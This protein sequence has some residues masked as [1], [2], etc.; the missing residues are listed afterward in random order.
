MSDGNAAVLQN[1]EKYDLE[2][3]TQDVQTETVDSFEN[4]I[5]E[6]IGILFESNKELVKEMKTMKEHQETILEEIRS[7]Q[8]KTNEKR[9][10]VPRAANSDSSTI[11]VEP[12]SQKDEQPSI[13]MKSFV[14]KHT[15]KSVS[16]YLLSQNVFSDEEEHFGIKWRI[17]VSHLENHLA[18]FVEC[19]ESF[20]TNNIK[21]IDIKFETKISKRDG[22]SKN[23][24]TSTVFGGPDIS[25]DKLVRDWGWKNLIE[26]EQLKK[27]FLVN[28]TMTVECHF[29]INKYVGIYKNNLR[30]FDETMEEFSDV[31]LV[32]KER[33]F[34]V[35]KLYLAAQSSYFKALFIGKFRESSQFEIELSGIDADDFQKYLEV[36]Y[37]EPAIDEYTVEGILMIS[38]M[39]DTQIIIKKCEEFLL[40]KSKK[41]LKKKLEMAVRC[42]LEKLK[43]KCLSEVTNVDILKSVIPRDIYDLDPSLTTIL[44]AKS[45]SFH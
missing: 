37:G 4:K 15:F 36:L 21:R 39:Y 5:F 30:E 17:R 23:M 18:C 34:Y 8:S 9:L 29:E 33:K 25:K 16:K 2:T 44:L 12:F 19:F 11:H 14:L 43:N 42:N 20:L 1:N 13:P 45:L 38:D 26:W 32:V 41:T 22:G 10:G 6:N 7:I 35:S 27:E 31:V 28:D 24:K 3:E 40:E